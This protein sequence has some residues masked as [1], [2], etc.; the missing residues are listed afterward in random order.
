MSLIVIR[1]RRVIRVRV[2]M[3]R[4]RMVWVRIG[5]VRIAMIRRVGGR[6]QRCR[7]VNLWGLMSMTRHLV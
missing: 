3:V 2:R 1:V 4:V 6:N 7:K 5:R